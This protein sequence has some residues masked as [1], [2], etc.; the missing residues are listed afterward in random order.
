[1]EKKS[2][3]P[4]AGRPGW[5]RL[6]LTALA[7]A[8]LVVA[9]AGIGAAGGGKAA[10]KAAIGIDATLTPLELLG[11]YVFFDKISARRAWPA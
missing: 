2:H 1:M 5:T 6:T 7:C 8:A 10:K 9:A 3:G 4:A 11:K